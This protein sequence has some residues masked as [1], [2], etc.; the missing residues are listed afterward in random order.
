MTQGW[1]SSRATEDEVGQRVLTLGSQ[2]AAELPLSQPTSAS[3]FF[4]PHSEADCLTQN[5]RKIAIVMSQ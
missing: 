5:V 1:L 3:N 4:T 2:L